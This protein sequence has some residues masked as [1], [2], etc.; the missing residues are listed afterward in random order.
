[1]KGAFTCR[2]WHIADARWERKPKA[3]MAP[4]TRASFAMTLHKTKAVLFG[5]A[6]DEEGK[7][8]EVLVSNFFN[9]LYQLNLAQWRWYPV[10]MKAQKPGAGVWSLLLQG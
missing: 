3:G 6:A 9:D 2:V 7:R 4:S 10:A 5:G 8:G 1:M